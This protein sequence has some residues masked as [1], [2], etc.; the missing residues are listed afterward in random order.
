M[1]ARIW[2]VLF[3]IFTTSCSAPTPIKT[4]DQSTHSRFS[5]IGGK[6]SSPEGPLKKYVVLI[7]DTPTNTYCT[8]LL[9]RKNVILTAAHCVEKNS[10][11]LT[12]AFGL[13][14]I[15]GQYILR[16]SDRVI[17]H[18]QYNKNNVTNRNDL[19]LLRIEGYAPSGFEPLKVAGEAFPLSPGLSFTAT[20]YG[21]SSEPQSSG[22]LRQVE[23]TIES[24]SDD[25]TQFFVN[26][27]TSKGICNGDSGGPALMRYLG[28]DYAVGVASALTWK[29]QKDAKD[30]CSERAIYISLKKYNSWI[31]QSVDD[32][33]KELQQQSSQ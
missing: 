22:I 2:L 25:G 33:L 19:A 14:P 29:N 32:L 10:I 9:I 18:P 15:K 23:L 7:F 1:T 26:Q 31:Q 28:T 21:R 16:K 11:N 30:V 4:K 24:L 5:I 12:L 20:G 3:F 13:A 27:K 8:G 6:E 17:S